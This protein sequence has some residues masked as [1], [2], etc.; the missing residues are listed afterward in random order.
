MG[1]D[2]ENS[3]VR[4]SNL[5]KPKNNKRISSGKKRRARDSNHV[6]RPVTLQEHQSRK[7]KISTEKTGPVR[8]VTTLE[9]SSDSESTNREAVTGERETTNAGS[10]TENSKKLEIH[11]DL[12]LDLCQETNASVEEAEEIVA[13]A[14]ERDA[15]TCD[16]RRDTKNPN[17]CQT[18]S[19][20]RKDSS[21]DVINE[22]K[23][24]NTCQNVIIRNETLKREITFDELV[25][26]DSEIL[27]TSTPTGDSSVR[28]R[29]RPKTCS[30][31]AKRK[32]SFGAFGRPK[33]SFTPR[34]VKYSE[35]CS[36]ASCCQ[37]SDFVNRPATSRSYRPS[38]GNTNMSNSPRRNMETR[39]SFKIT[40]EDLEHSLPKTSFF[41]CHDKVLKDAGI[42]VE[43][44]SPLGAKKR[45][46]MQLLQQRNKDRIE[47]DKAR[48]IPPPK[49]LGMLELYELECS[50]DDSNTSSLVSFEDQQSNNK[51][52]K[53]AKSRK[54]G[55]LDEEEIRVDYQLLLIYL[56]YVKANPAEFLQYHKK[57]AASVNLVNVRQG[58]SLVKLGGIFQRGRHG[59]STENILVKA[60]H[61]IRPRFTDPGQ[62]ASANKEKE[63]L[64]LTSTKKENA[65]PPKTE[66]TKKETASNQEEPKT[67]YE[68]IKIKLDGWL[69]TVT[70]AQLNKAK[71]LALREL[72]QEDISLSRWWVSLKSCNYIRQRGHKV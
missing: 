49:V 41:N 34:T 28:S 39:R 62:W 32:G 24:T 51:S 5:N 47:K 42:E 59:V 60:V 53:N 13:S 11:V 58:D 12:R 55:D 44:V 21:L 38:T 3:E 48:K 7:Q 54:K 17:R 29:V 63:L 45:Q 31:V 71:E 43:E 36:P 50:Q 61:E 22:E 66:Q 19:I 14:N 35:T 68:R 37:F 16:N 10:L 9:G 57:H 26:D 18:K 1:S 25:L 52:K 6:V 27:R 69:K 20:A 64:A 72:G 65:I 4:N 67:E 46:F 70:T 30:S 40:K 23:E 2:K 56:R 33:S 15:V 8:N